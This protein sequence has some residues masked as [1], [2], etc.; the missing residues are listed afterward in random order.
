MPFHGERNKRFSRLFGG[1]RLPSRHRG[2]PLA[3][4]VEDLLNPLI[5][6]LLCERG[7]DAN[8]SGPWKS[9]LEV[10]VKRDRLSTVTILVENGADV[11][12]PPSSSD[13]ILALACTDGSL[14]MVR[15][16]LDKGATDRVKDHSLLSSAMACAASREDDAILRL[17]LERGHIVNR[18]SGYHSV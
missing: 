16:L 17:L 9:V 6:N 13:S 4:A 14:D 1:S 10:A 12:A 2:V 7:A 15:Y 18:Q 3:Y 11:N 5:G 8:D